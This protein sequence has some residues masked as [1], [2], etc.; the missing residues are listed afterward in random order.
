MLIAILQSVSACVILLSIVLLRGRKIRL[1]RT[2]AQQVVLA[3]AYFDQNG[4]I[5]L[6]RDG[7]LPCEK[8]TNRFVEK[9]RTCHTMKK[10]LLTQF[11]LS[12]RMS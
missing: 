12:V 2:R 3:C 10:L 5:M 11:R 8:I 6:T 4:R 1:T 9:V 7:T